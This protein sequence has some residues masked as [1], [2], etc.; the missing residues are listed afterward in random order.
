MKSVACSFTAGTVIVAALCVL[1]FGTAASGFKMRDTTLDL[2]EIVWHPEKPQ[3]GW[4]CGIDR[5][6]KTDSKKQKTDRHRHRHTHRHTH[7]HR[8][9]HRHKHRHRHTDTHRHTHSRTHA[10]THTQTDT[11]RHTNSH[12]HKTKPGV[13]WKPHDCEAPWRKHPDGSRP[14]WKRK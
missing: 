6:G 2:N 12:F 4:L 7:R 13:Y 11:D 8:H 3:V 5:A 1:L 9:R 14:V 10:H